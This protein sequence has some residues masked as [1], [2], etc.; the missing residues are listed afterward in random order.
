MANRGSIPKVMEMAGID[1]LPPSEG[2]PVVRR[3]LTAAGPGTEVLV[4]GA[5]G[6]MLEERHPTGGLDLDAATKAIDAHHGP[7]SGQGRRVQLARWAHGPNRARSEPPGVPLRPP[8]R[9]HAGAAGRDGN[10]GVRG[11]RGRA[12]ARL[13]GDGAR[14]R[15]A[16]RA[17]QVLPR[18]AA[19]TASSRCGTAARGDGTLV[20]D[21]RL[22]GTRSLPAGRAADR[23][24]HR[25]RRPRP[26]ASPTAQ[27]RCA[28]R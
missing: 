26:R 8:D 6:V 15:R 25:S 2:V 11:G 18:R 12:P 19:R 9:G 20:A 5:L 21:C 28:G 3:E 4:A 16:D 17:V 13:A 22:V 10:R 7:M 24:L 14:G 1:M 23:A 27:G